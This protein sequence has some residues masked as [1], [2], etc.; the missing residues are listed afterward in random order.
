MKNTGI[1]LIAVL[2]LAV[3]TPALAQLEVVTNNASNPN[4]YDPDCVK[5]GEYAMRVTTTVGDT[6]ARFV[7][8]GASN[9]FDNETTVRAQFWFH[10]G[11]MTEDHGYKHFVLAAT[12]GPGSLQNLAPFRVSFHKNAYTGDKKLAFRC[13]T[14]CTPVPGGQCTSVGGPKV[15]LAPN[16]WNLIQIEWSHNTPGLWDGICRIS[17]IDGP[18][19]GAVSETPNSCRQYAVGTVKMGFTGGA[20]I[21]TSTDGNHCYDDFASFRTLAP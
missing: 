20:A 17:I 1:I 21:H 14:N 18:A 7:E 10:P 4:P 13:K 5:N 8:A 11:S 19:A 16:D 2:A 15:T 6:A 3:A 9:G 12:P